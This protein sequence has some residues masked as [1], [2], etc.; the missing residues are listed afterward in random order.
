M[1][2][3][4]SRILFSVRC[5]PGRPFLNARVLNDTKVS[6]CSY[7]SLTCI[8]HSVSMNAIY[9]RIFASFAIVNLSFNDN[10]NIKTESNEERVLHLSSSLCASAAC[11]RL[12][13]P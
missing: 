4:V 6:C 2:A 11:G 5:Y 9:E 3:G 1:A 7:L 13:L 10:N 12:F 8:L